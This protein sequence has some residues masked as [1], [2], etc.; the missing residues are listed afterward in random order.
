MHVGDHR[1][2]K[3]APEETT[4]AACENTITR[5]GSWGRRWKEHTGALIVGKKKLVRKK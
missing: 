1:N 3:K 2:R 5:C 4:F